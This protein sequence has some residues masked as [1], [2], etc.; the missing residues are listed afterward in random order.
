MTVKKNG[1]E[2]TVK[3]LDIVKNP[4]DW[5]RALE[6]YLSGNIQNVHCPICNSA[7]EAKAASAKLKFQIKQGAIGQ[8]LLQLARCRGMN[9][10]FYHN[11]PP[12]KTL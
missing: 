11:A 9:E 5:I 7:V 3:K 10:N 8:K 2:T 1:G 4:T 12:L 6:M